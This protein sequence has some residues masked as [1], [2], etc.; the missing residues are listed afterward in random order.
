MSY[1]YV[2]RSRSIYMSSVRQSHCSAFTLKRV[3][4]APVAFDTRRCI[5]SDAGA[6]GACARGRGADEVRDRRGGPGRRLDSHPEGPILITD[7]LPILI[8]VFNYLLGGSTRI[9]KARALAQCIL[10]R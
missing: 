7:L 9:P 5:G 6:R 8:T 3:L 4:D 2:S 10:S 1:I